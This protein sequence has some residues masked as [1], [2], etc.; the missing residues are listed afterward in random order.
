MVEYEEIEMSLRNKFPNLFKLN[1]PASEALDYLVN[2]YDFRGKDI[3]QSLL[4]M[5][6]QMMEDPLVDMDRIPFDRFL[7]FAWIMSEYGID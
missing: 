7:Y 6:D 5:R 4:D 2:L 3:P 1:P